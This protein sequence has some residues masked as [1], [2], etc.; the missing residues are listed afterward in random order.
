MEKETHSQRII[1]FVIIFYFHFCTVKCSNRLLKENITK[2]KIIRRKD[3][4]Q[5]KQ[6]HNKAKTIKATT[7]AK[8]MF[9]IKN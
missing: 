4:L 9:V 3:F 1:Y 6:K 8:M 2:T 7:A 5:A